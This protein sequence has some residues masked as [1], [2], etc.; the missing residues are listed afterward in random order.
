LE[1]RAAVAA[2]ESEL[3]EPVEQLGI[4]DPRGLEELRV[5]ARRREA[6]DRVQLVDDDLPALADEEVHA[7]HALAI[8][9]DEGCDGELL[10]PRDRAFVEPRRND[11]LHAAFVV[12]G[13]E[14]VPV[15]RER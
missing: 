9:R 7:R 3:D 15:G 1:A 13:G 10:Y 14:V 6:G 8:A 2:L 5:D 11:E 4:S 12:L